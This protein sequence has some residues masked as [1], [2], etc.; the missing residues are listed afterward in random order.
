MV[1][2]VATD[3]GAKSAGLAQCSHSLFAHTV[4]ETSLV[5]FL[6]SRFGNSFRNCAKSPVGQRCSTFLP[7]GAARPEQ[8]LPVDNL[9]ACNETQTLA[10]FTSVAVVESPLAF[11]QPMEVLS[12]Q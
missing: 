3:R 9:T 10:Q 2:V 7:F 5:V 11:L 8:L 1:Y 12:L 4:S 6:E